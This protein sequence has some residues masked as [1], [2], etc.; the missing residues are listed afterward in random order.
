M[1]L[2]EV[3][4]AIMVVSIVVSVVVSRYLLKVVKGTDSVALEAD[5]RNI[6]D[7][8]NLWSVF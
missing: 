3:G 7:E 1:E 6:T 2:S 4:I 8:S 5:A